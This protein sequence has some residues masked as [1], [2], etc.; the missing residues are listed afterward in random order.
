VSKEVKS[1]IK[2]LL[3]KNPSH[4]IGSLKGIKEIMAHP[5]FKVQDSEAIQLSDAFLYDNG[6]SG[7]R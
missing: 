7:K 4:R 1:L 3:A 2:G 5:W 6:R